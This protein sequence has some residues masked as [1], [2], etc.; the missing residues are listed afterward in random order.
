MHTLS[1]PQRALQQRPCILLSYDQCFHEM[2]TVLQDVPL[3]SV[4]A[5]VQCQWLKF[6]WPWFFRSGLSGG[7]GGGSGGG[8]RGGHRI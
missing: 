6:L 4:M 5:V 8:L 2:G 3:A 1:S 7:G